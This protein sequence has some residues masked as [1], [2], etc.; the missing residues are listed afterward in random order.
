[1]AWFSAVYLQQHSFW[2]KLDGLLKMW[3]IHGPQRIHSNNCRSSDVWP[4]AVVRS[5]FQLV[6]YFLVCDK[7][8]KQHCHQPQL[9]FVFGANNQMLDCSHANMLNKG[10]EYC[11]DNLPN[12]SMVWFCITHVSLP[13]FAFTC[14]G[15]FHFHIQDSFFN[16]KNRYQ[17]KMWLLFLNQITF[18]LY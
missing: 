15:T 16:I 1:M 7:I 5:K 14:H 11:K 18:F 9:Y 4:R 10:D 13:V 3:H 12:I 17:W 2:Q 8:V 6:Q